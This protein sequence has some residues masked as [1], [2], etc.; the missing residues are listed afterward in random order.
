MIDLQGGIISKWRA[1]EALPG[2]LEEA[3]RVRDLDAVVFYLLLHLESLAT[4]ESF[5]EVAGLLIPELSPTLASVVGRMTE[6]K[7]AD[8]RSRSLRIMRRGAARS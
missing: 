4:R 6:T 2:E 3:I 8:P 5:S 7:G 1:G